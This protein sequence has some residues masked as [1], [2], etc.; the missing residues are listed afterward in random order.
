MFKKRLRSSRYKGLD[1]PTNKNEW[2]EAINSSKLD[3]SANLNCP[4]LPAAW[5]SHYSVIFSIVNYAV[6]AFYSKFL[7]SVLPSSLTQAQVLPVSVD[8]VI[9]TVKKLKS[10]SRL[11]LTELV[12]IILK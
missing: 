3:N 10:S 9:A 6:H 11:M 12:F 8:G 7:D 1:C 2:G 4:I 5:S